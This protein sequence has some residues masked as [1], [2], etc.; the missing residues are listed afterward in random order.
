[1]SLK[2]ISPQEAKALIDQGAVL[3]DIREP[4]E[5]AR[6]YIPGS[7][8]LPLSRTGAGE[9]VAPGASKV[10]FHCKSGMRTSGNAETLANC[11]T[12]EGYIVEGGLDAWAAA[13]LPVKVDSKQP[14]ELM[15]QVQITAGTM[16]LAG[17]L[18]GAYVAPGWYG[19]SAFVGA[20]L[21][22]AGASGWCGMAKLLA[23]MPWN[24]RAS[25]SAPA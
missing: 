3:V 20:G 22:F 16:V 13:G 17:V 10:I 25:A 18:L 8:S 23:V 4:Q 11:A 9:R 6:S 12:C 5:R 24:R 15:R 7:Q 19:L 1:M 2:K 14:I 21:V